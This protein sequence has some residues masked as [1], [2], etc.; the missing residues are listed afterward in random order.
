MISKG[1]SVGCYLI[2]GV[3]LISGSRSVGCYPIS[4]GIF[5][6]WGSVSGVLSNQWGYI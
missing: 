5:D 1:R 6:Q 4:G 2:S 3:Y